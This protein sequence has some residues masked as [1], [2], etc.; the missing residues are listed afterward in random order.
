M[1]FRGI[2]LA[3]WN[4]ERDRRGSHFL[5]E[6]RGWWAALDTTADDDRKEPEEPDDCRTSNTSADYGCA[7]DTGSGFY[8]NMDI[9][10]HVRVRE[11]CDGPG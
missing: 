10:I 4:I 5:P 1:R 9:Y 3:H 7:V 11:A 2:Q 6:L 8:A